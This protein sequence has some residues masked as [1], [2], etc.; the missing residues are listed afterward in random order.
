MKAVSVT[1]N[2]LSLRLMKLL[3]MCLTPVVYSM[4]LPIP[5]PSPP[6][7]PLPHAFRA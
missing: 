7:S 1:L 2:L 4:E 5:L 3:R 6:I